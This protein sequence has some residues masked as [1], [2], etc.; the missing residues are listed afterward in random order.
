MT[1]NASRFTDRTLFLLRLLWGILA[2]VF[3]V[4]FVLSMPQAVQKAGQAPPVWLD[5]A[6]Q[7]L[8]LILGIFLFWQRP[9]DWVAGVFS[10]TLI[11]A[12]ATDRWQTVFGDNTVTV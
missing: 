2:V 8:Y 5:I 1:P 7:A 11:M 12:L 10:L 6:L 3:T 9:N 4:L